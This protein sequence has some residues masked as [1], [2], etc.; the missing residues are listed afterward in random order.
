MATRTGGT[1]GTRLLGR[2]KER[3]LLDAAIA[4]IQSGQSRV[5]LLRGEAGVGK[6]ALL[7]YLIRSASGLRVLRAVGVESEMEL[8]YAGLHQLCA[9]MLD[10]V[11]R[12]PAPQRDALRIVFQAADGAPPDVFLVGLAVLS[13]IAEV[14]EEQP[15]LCVVDDAQ[16]LDRASA[17]TLTFVGRRLLADPVGL[18]IAA[19]EPSED[20]KGLPELEVRGLSNGDARALLAS[21]VRFRLDEGIRDQIVAETQGNPLALLELPRGLS[22]TQ[23]AGGFGILP[24]PGVPGRIEQS[25][26]R[27]IATLPEDTRSLLLI[28]AAEPVGDPLLLWRAADRRGLGLVPFGSVETDELL[29]IDARVTFRHPLVRSAVYRTAQPEDRRAAHLALAEVTDPDQDPDRRAWHLA[30]ATAAPDED[31]AAELERSAGRAQSRGG[32]AAAAAFLEQSVRLS[33][34]SARRTDRALAAAEASLNG[35]AFHEALSMLAVARE[36]PLDELQRGRLDLLQAAAAHAQHRGSDAPPLLLR[37]AKTLQP[38][39]LKLARDT[40]LDAWCAALFAGEL[41]REGNLYELSRVARG[42]PASSEPPRSSEL[43]LDGL[44]LLLT[45][46]RRAATP[47]L[48]EAT[49]AFAG[50]GASIEEVLR[51]GWLATVAAVAIWDYETCVA[52]AGRAVQAARDTGALTVLAVALNILAQAVTMS[53]DF[54]KAAQLISEAN[55]VTEATGTPVAPYGEIFI[56]AFRGGEAEL[57]TLIDATVADAEAAGQGTYVQYTRWAPSVILNGFGRHEEAV[58]PAQEAA[59]DTP[60]LV[61]AGWSLCEL[62]EAAARSGEVELAESALARIAERNEVVST[63]WGLGLEARGRALLSEDETADGLYREAIERL[64]RTPLRPELAR[65]HLLYGEWLRRHGQRADAQAQLRTAYEL[66]AD[67]GMEAFAE[68]ARVELAATGEK[69]RKRTD[70]TRGD[71][72]PQ[73]RQIA[74]LARSGLSNSEIG[75]RLFLSPRTVEWHLHHVFTKLGIGSR[76]GLRE[77]LGSPGA[78]QTPP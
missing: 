6:T 30:A 24:G 8:A 78:N 48:Q 54:E 28:A 2:N 49:I 41:A 62:V 74:E 57:S 40:Y 18:V 42:V 34:D 56:T 38:L 44:T 66:C 25:F 4:A 9:P 14:A 65:A 13:L 60:E 22:P 26:E 29:S 76:R 37:A 7:E 35:G 70:A 36:G 75:A 47:V 17:R 11:D 58:R 52:A 61:V 50:D 59:E 64:G 51:W 77:A 72:T 46:G 21:A 27:R 31:V 1:A 39:D 10:R 15:L 55:V 5:L 12:L 20:L 16:W 43:L 63:D 73:E 68:R 3:T 32:I 53:G 69:V 67:I 19:R 23:L 71:L 33:G 45:E